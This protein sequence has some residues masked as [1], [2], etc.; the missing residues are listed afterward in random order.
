M[1]SHLP[2][3][4][5]RQCGDAWP[6]RLVDRR[7]PVW[8]KALPDAPEHGNRQIPLKGNNG[9]LLSIEQFAS[10]RKATARGRSARIRTIE[11]D[12]GDSIQPMG[13]NEPRI[14]D[15]LREIEEERPWRS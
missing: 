6:W 1:D 9:G 12:L 13:G 3:G 15:A 4:D 11:S 8:E 2:G 7:S 10:N 14:G 5:M